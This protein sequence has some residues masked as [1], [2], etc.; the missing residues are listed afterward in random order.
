MPLATGVSDVDSVGLSPF[1]LTAIGCVFEMVDDESLDG[2]S[3]L[4]GAGGANFCRLVGDSFRV[5][6]ILP[7]ED[8]RRAPGAEAGFAEV[9]AIVELGGEGGCEGWKRKQEVS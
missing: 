4:T 2:D 1:E 9:E 8:F 6:I 5:M 3:S 7:F